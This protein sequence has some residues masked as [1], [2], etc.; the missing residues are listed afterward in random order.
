MLLK[1]HA[2]LILFTFFSNFSFAQSDF[3]YQYN[4]EN[5]LPSSYLKQ[6]IQIESGELLITSDNGLAL[7]DGYS[8]RSFSTINGLPSNYVKY[9]LIDRTGKMWIGTDGGLAY[10]FFSSGKD[11]KFTKFNL[12]PSNPDVKALRLFEDSKNRI[13]VASDKGIYLIQNDKPVRMDFGKQVTFLSDYVRSFSFTEDKNG[14]IWIT[15]LGEGVYV[16]QNSG[17]TLRQLNLPGLPK[18]TRSIYKFSDSEFWIGT[19]AGLFSVSVNAA[20]P[21]RSIPKLLTGSILYADAVTKENETSFYFGTD[22]YGFYNYNPVKNEVKKQESLSSD[23]IKDVFVDR[24]KNIWVAS[25]DGL[26]LLPYTL[27]DNISTAQN[28]PKRYVSGSVEDR[29]GN[30]WISNY[31]GMYKRE[32]NSTRVVKTP[33]N[34]NGIFIKNLVYNSKTNLIYVFGRTDIYELNPSTSQARLIKS[35]PSSYE[36]ESAFLDRQNSLWLLTTTPAIFRFSL[37]DNSLDLFDKKNGIPVSIKSASQGTDGNLWFGGANRTLLIYNSSNGNFS[38]FNWKNQEIKPDSLATIDCL[39][40]DSWN[41]LWIGGTDGVYRLSADQKIEKIEASGEAKMDNLRF[42]TGSRFDIWIGTNRYLFQINLNENGD[43]SVIRGFNKKDG[44][45]ST[46]FSYRSAFLHESGRF[47]M[48]SNLGLSYYKG[49]AFQERLTPLK[50]NSWQSNE[51]THYGTDDVELEPGNNTVT[52]NVVC[53]NYPTDEI[54]YQTRMIGLN[55]KWTTPS[56][57]RFLSATLTNSGQYE[58]Q[59]RALTKGGLQTEILSV[60]FTIPPPVWLRWYF[61]VFYIV[62]AVGGIFLF[63]TWRSKALETKNRELESFVAQRTTEIMKRDQELKELIQQMDEKGSLLSKESISLNHNITTMTASSV[64]QS[65][66]IAQTT[67]TMEEL[68]KSNEMIEHSAGKVA[69]MISHTQSIIYNVNT[70]AQQSTEFM[71]KVQTANE[72]Q[73]QKIQDL[74]QKIENIKKISSFIENLNDQTQLI[75]FNAAIEATVAGEVGRRF[76][77]I[78]DEIR[79]LANDINSSTREINQTLNSM[80]DEISDVV[81]LS[82]KNRKGIEEG[83]RLNHEVSK[84]FE[85]L[86]DAAVEASTATNN[87]TVSTSQQSSANEQMVT[88]LREIADSSNHLVEI[89]KDIS[90]T[91]HQMEEMANYFLKL[92]Q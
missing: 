71:T 43:I 35:V 6:I 79:F 3:R 61:V 52:F 64:Q 84:A 16:Y 78:A 42:M 45:L 30:L 59:A 33:Q 74:A 10:T 14:N 24:Q 20:A 49:S 46:S 69:E 5:G 32:K 7:F 18:I 53:I 38:P 85:T 2:F 81:K 15:T 29:E 31:E 72:I 47:Y 86:N 92:K 28:L 41:R 60:K 48:G 23:Y 66:A 11:Q 51:Q 4:L 17:N 88:S 39:M 19:S 40:P 34:L 12:D 90:L 83:V 36:I 13:W 75:A 22:G 56:R 57:N 65:S 37:A 70:L 67:A 9:V 1:K 87:I 58:M 62:F 27:F 89:I 8:F 91:S 77:V 25:D 26:T 76:K 73:V 68:A 44:L 80:V 21:E 55:D 50:L 82:D 63:I 54:L